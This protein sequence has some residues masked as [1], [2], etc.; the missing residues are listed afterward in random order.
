MLN[1]PVGLGSLYPSRVLALRDLR[2]ALGRDETTGD[3]P[4]NHSWIGL[5]L[6]L[7]VLDTLTG[8]GT[9]DVGKKW[10][11][12]LT[13]HGI[14]ER[15]A[16]A[17]YKLRCSMVHG[18]GIPLLGDG[19]NVQLTAYQHGYAVDTESPDVISV[20]VP[21]FC[22]CLVERVAYE[23][24]DQWDETLIDTRARNLRRA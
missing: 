22:R 12:L 2:T 18:Y 13:D 14:H 23:A 17:I 15:D 6:G 9:K 20:S 1:C 8:P 21:V 10:L 4:G 7:V 24:G 16:D 5:T 11:R 3:R 19:R